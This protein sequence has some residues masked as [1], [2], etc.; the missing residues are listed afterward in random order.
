MAHDAPLPPLDSGEVH[1]WRLDLSGAAPQ[2]HLDFLSPEERRRADRFLS[3]DARRR[4]VLTRATL[5]RLLAGYAGCAPRDLQLGEGGQGKPFL[6]AALD[7]ASP[8]TAIEFNCSHAE[9]VALIA[10]TRGTPVGVDV[11]DTARRI[12]CAGVARRW[13]TAPEQAAWAAEGESRETFFRIWTRKE[14]V[15]KAHG[16]GIAVGW[17][18]ISVA[19][20]VSSK[21]R[22]PGEVAWQGKP[23]A[24]ADLTPG[25]GEIGAL[26]V[27]GA[28][29]RLR[30]FLV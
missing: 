14:A 17:T 4:Y 8:R 6:S 24:L 1:L 30:V 12:D 11:E 15:A 28:M 10:C 18:D 13:F 19:E 16:G 7:P 21:A 22:W 23:F 5:R 26:A 2:G 20:M 27:A 25:A 29:G 3:A 9:K